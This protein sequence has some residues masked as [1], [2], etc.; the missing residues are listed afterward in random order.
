VFCQWV[1][2]YETSGRSVHTILDTLSASFPHVQLFSSQLITDI[3]LLASEEPLR[4][5][6]GAAELFPDRKEVAP[7]LERVG[8]RNLPDLALRYTA[9]VPHPPR[10]AELNTDDNS[11][12]QYRAP[13]EGLR[14]YFEPSASRRIA[15]S[16]A[17]LMELFF[18]GR[19]EA[20]VLPELARAAQRLGAKATVESIAGYLGQKGLPALE[21]QV[22]A[23]ASTTVAVGTAATA[24]S[25]L[26]L[27][28]ERIRLRD[29]L[30]AI[31]ALRQ[32]EEKGL[33]GADQ[34]S[35]SGYVLLKVRRYADAE[36]RLDRAAADVASPAH[37]RALAGRGAAR[38]H[39]GRREEGLKDIAAAKSISPMDPLAYLLLGLA[40]K[41]VGDVSAA[42]REMQAGLKI[43][44]NDPPLVHAL[45]GLK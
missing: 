44:P 29:G 9:P 40:Y 30:G 1:Q 11:L 13:L 31:D 19:S 20:E 27:A 34:L 7:D 10:E 45:E 38:Y 22:R 33:D 15:P 16:P 17:A 21:Q 36:K 24:D 12:I 3:I 2:V 25:L 23:M 41:D 39:L 6:P 37:Y 28:E 18:P 8:V 26:V 14:F 4:L 43:A 35:R 42:R 5:A 32:A